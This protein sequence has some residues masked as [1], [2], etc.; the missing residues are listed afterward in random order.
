[1]P[2]GKPAGVRCVHLD[3]RERCRL[4][5]QP[6]RPAVCTSLQPSAEMCGA[7][8]EEALR[9]LTWLEVQTLPSARK[10]R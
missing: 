3:E 4:F 2:N 10:M 7:N 1:M 6:N 9:Y 5:G 8:R